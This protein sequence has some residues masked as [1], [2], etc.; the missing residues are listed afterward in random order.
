MSCY[1]KIFYSLITL[2]VS[3]YLYYKKEIKKKKGSN[4]LIYKINY[5]ICIFTC[6]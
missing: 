4:I 3:F 1:K 2:Y 6:L 5:I